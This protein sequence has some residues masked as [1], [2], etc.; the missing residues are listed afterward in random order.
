[1]MLTTHPRLAP[2]LRMSGSIPELPV[3]A[4]MVRTGVALPP[5]FPLLTRLRSGG[6]IH[7]PTEGREFSNRNAA[8]GARLASYTMGAVGSC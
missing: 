7:I 8:P 2:K 5:S 1:V 6:G 3:Y 4:F